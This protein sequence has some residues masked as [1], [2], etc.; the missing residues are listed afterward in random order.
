MQRTSS[1][2]WSGVVDLI[3]QV[4]AEDDLMASVVAGVRTVVQEV[5]SLPAADIAGH[6]RALLTAAT[7]ALAGRRGPT[8]A[9]LAF[10]EELAV[11]RAGQGIPIEGVLGAIHVA[12][13]AIWARARELAQGRGLD[14]A[15]LL[16]ARE[17][18]DDWAEAVRR[19]LIRAHREARD[20]QDRS[21]R[22]PG[23]WGGAQRIRDA[24]LLRR[25]LEGGSAAV[26]AAAEAGLP[27]GGALWVLVARGSDQ[28]ATAALERL[29]REHSPA[30]A[31][32]VGDVVVAV[33]A[34]RPLGRASETGVVGLAGP[35]GPEEAGAAHRFA[36]SAVAAAEATGRTGLVHVADV[37]SVA[38]VLSRRDLAT[39]LVARH[40]D[41]HAR[42][43][44]HVIPVAR[45]VRSWLECDRDT[46]RAAG[47]LFVHANTVRNRVQRFTQVTGLDPLDTFGAVD[48][49]WLCHEWLAETG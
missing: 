32:R 24:E 6:T 26:L 43:G 9:E 18:Y 1:P 37:A 39:S 28:A 7:R 16:D 47:E 10:V 3:E 25:L 22:D 38:A 34:R 20:A 31:A 12:E 21:D 23:G 19:R 8:E 27:P 41:G 2:D 17:L 40:R 5:S 13:R 29:A 14:P 11:T 30:C 4:L 36:T 48:A 44:E 15:R 33:V 49:W 45:A 35:V 42:L 46:A